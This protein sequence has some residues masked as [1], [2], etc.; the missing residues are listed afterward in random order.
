MNI[1]NAIQIFNWIAMLLPLATLIVL[2]VHSKKHKYNPLYWALIIIFIPI[3]GAL[4][5]YVKLLRF[6]NTS[7]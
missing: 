2:A 3:I 4:L 6:N 7:I 5:Y 1:T